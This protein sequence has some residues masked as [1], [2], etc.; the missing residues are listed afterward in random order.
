MPQYKQHKRQADALEDMKKRAKLAK[1]PSKTRAD[2]CTNKSCGN[3]FCA[4]AE[5]LQ[6]ELP[7][8]DD[9]AARK[10]LMERYHY[11]WYSSR[12]QVKHVQHALTAC[13]CTL[14]EATAQ[15]M[16]PVSASPAARPV[17]DSLGM[18]LASHTCFEMLSPIQA[19]QDSSFQLLQSAVPHHETWSS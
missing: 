19:Y 17:C 15:F 6:Q 1:Y 14:P 7:F 12:L 5:A 8:L 3:P 10:L 4:A 2:S 9:V 13:W 18:Q 16:L 11:E